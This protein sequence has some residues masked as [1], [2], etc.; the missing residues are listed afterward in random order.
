MANQK[1][2]DDFFLTELAKKSGISYI[3]GKF[4]NSKKEEITIKIDGYI[5]KIYSNLT[6]KNINN[7]DLD[8]IKNSLIFESQIN[9]V[10]LWY[11][12]TI[13]AEAKEKIKKGYQVEKIPFEL[14]KKQLI[15]LNVLMFHS[16]Y[17][18]MFISTGI[19]GSGKSTFLNIIQQLF[20]RDTSN[21]TL[22]D[23]A[24]PFERAEA[25]KHRLICSDELSSDDL[26]LPSL[27]TII[28]KQYMS[29]NNKY[30]RV[31]TI[32]CQ[33]NLFYCCNI[34][35]RLDLS[36][37]GILRRIIFYKRN[38][39]IKNPN[40]LLKDKKYTR[41]ELIDFIVEAY[42][43]DCTPQEIEDTFFKET[44][45][46]LFS[47]NSVIKYYQEYVLKNHFLLNYSA[48]R[49]Y[50]SENGFRA[51]NISNFNDV[52]ELY[53]ERKEKE[54]ETYEKTFDFEIPF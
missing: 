44:N 1:K 47:Q 22:S 35:P 10:F 40:V 16:N 31:E 51:F 38:T 26:D 48:Y 4:F 6:N 53:K 43:Y 42:K 5:N 20:E 52:L 18:Y 14:D 37:T 3:S 28:S 19:G 24:N 12:P 27:K 23:L 17:E 45:E 41:E 34:A 2:F 54:K 39:K 33:S 8:Y 30:G 9:D 46:F 32:K 13:L 49:E 50:C 15:I 25:L 21:T 7:R 11:E 36:D 29:I